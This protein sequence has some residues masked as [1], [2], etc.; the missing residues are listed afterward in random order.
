MKKTPLPIAVSVV[1]A[2]ASVVLSSTAAASSGALA[3][4]WTSLDTDGS[5]QTLNVMGSGQRAY[6]M[7]YIDDAATG[8]CGGDPAR[9]TGP[10]YVDGDSVFLA[11]ALVCLPGGNE[12]R[13]RIG[14]RFDYDSG[15]DTLTDEFGIVWHRA[16]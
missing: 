11:G 13:E 15:S 4:T 16:G 10:G 6:S 3:G 5:H 8:A 12:F 7:V 1:F 2:S 9:I 14:I